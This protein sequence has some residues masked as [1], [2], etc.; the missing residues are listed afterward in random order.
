MSKVLIYDTTLRDGAQGENVYFSVEDKIKIAKKLDELGVDYIEGGWPGSNPK[1]MEFFRR[2]EN[3]QFSHA[4]LVAF[5]STKRA[6]NSV[7]NDPVLQDLLAAGTPA[8]AIFGKSWDFHVN[9]VL[10]ITLD[11]NIK[12]I[13]DSVSYLKKHHKEVIYDAEHFYDGYKHN[14]EYAIQTLQAALRGGADFIVLCDTNGGTL[15]YEAVNILKK[16]RSVITAP[17]GIH[18]HND[19]GMA[20]SISILSVQE[21]AVQVQGTFNGY[22]ERCGNANLCTIIPNLLLKLGY[23]SAITPNLGALTET[24]KFISELSNLPHDTRL[25]IL[26]RQ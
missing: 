10:R 5:G 4:K 8:I 6:G 26:R 1:D 2:M 11:D 20:T 16:V 12:I 17:L 19:C 13:E 3:Y 9:E 24:S 23:K 7:E 14:P 25:S 15:P 18:I 21:G 22:G